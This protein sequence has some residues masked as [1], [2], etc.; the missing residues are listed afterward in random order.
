MRTKPVKIVATIGPA[1]HSKEM[2]LD[3]A[4]AGV[5]VFRL[6]LSHAEPHEVAERC[7]WIR[8]AETVINKPLAILGDLPGPKN[9]S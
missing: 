3:L 1:S 4:R 8:E 6:N 7:E 2:I 5:D 9:S